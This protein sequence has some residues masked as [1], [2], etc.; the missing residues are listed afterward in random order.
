MKMQL[1][2]ITQVK[3]ERFLFRF[4]SK[5]ARLGDDG[6]S[7]ASSCGECFHNKLCSSFS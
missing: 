2:M 6:E 7:N 1:C 4:A 3:N 5:C